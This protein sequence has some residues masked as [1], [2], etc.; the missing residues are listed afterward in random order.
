MKRLMHSLVAL[1]PL[2]AAAAAAQPAGE[3]PIPVP[4]P[5]DMFISAVRPDDWLREEATDPNPRPVV[6]QRF[7]EFR[8]S[9]PGSVFN[10]AQPMPLEI[11]MVFMDDVVEPVIIE[12]IEDVER[13]GTVLRVVQGRVKSDEMSQINLVFSRYRVRGRIHYQDTVIEMRPVSE[14]VT[15]IQ[16]ID[17]NRFPRE[18]PPRLAQRDP[19]FALEPSLVQAKLSTDLSETLAEPFEG[20]PLAALGYEAP[21]ISV[22]LV[23]SVENGGCDDQTL[24]EY[25]E[26]YQTSLNTAFASYATSRVEYRCVNQTEDW[27]TLEEARQF[28]RDHTMI[29]TLRTEVDADLVVMLL[30]DGLGAC[31]YTMHPDYPLYPIDEN[32]QDYARKAAFAVV[33]EGCAASN[34]SLEHEIGHLLGMKHDRFNQLG[35]VD[36]FCGYGYPVMQGHRP[37][38]RT[39]MAYDSYCTYVG[40]D[41][42]R[43]PF[44]SIPKQKAGGPFGWLV[45]MLRKC[46]TR[47]KGMSCDSAGV[48]H[49]DKPA[50]DTMQIVIAAE[51][52]A[53]YSEQLLPP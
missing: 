32:L 4:G 15:A 37:V 35:G 19:S 6:Q 13:D 39:I 18:L 27:A 53:K 42:P 5:V 31:G 50:N 23:K 45:N 11:T 49:L 3:I 12:R 25:A 29:T 8:G 28:L 9:L 41:C 34:L 46:F 43:R 52:V 48:H 2:L 1:S 38:V 26:D 22:L 20:Q 10:P 44:Y 51:D 17:P 40:T 7:V 47:I 33:D 30:K 16:R 14:R 24:S 21:E 36:S